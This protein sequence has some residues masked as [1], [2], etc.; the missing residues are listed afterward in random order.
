MVGHAQ[1]THGNRVDGHTVIA[2]TL[3]KLGV[4]HI[5]GMSGSP[6]RETLPACSKAG[7]RPI[8]VHNQQAAVMMA[9]A[10]NFVGGQLTGVAILSAGPAITNA[11]TGVL[12]AKDNGWPVVVLG[13]RRPLNMKGMGSFQELDAIPI[14][15]SITKWAAVI[16]TTADIPDYLSRAVQV[17]TTGRPGPVY[18]DVSEEALMGT[19]SEWDSL[20]SESSV[21]PR[22]DSHTISKA[23]DI[24]LQ[25]KRPALIIGTDIRWSE[26]YE[27]LQKLVD[28]LNLPFITSP[29]GRGFL[30]DDHPL[31]FNAARGLLQ[32]KADVVLLVG[33]RLD[34]TFRFGTELTS[35]AKLILVDSHDQ[36]IGMNRSPDVG[37]IGDVPYVLQE[38]LDQLDIERQGNAK[39]KIHDD[40][41]SLLK[42]RRVQN[43]QTLESRMT[44]DTIP[45][46]P[47]RLAKEIRDFLPSNAI[48][49]LDGNV[50]MAAAQ[51]V[52]PTY[53]PASRLT[54]G[55]NGCMGVGIPFGIG[56]KLTCP[57][58]LVVVICGDLAFGINAMEMETAI[59]HKIP[60]IVV[61]A[62]N[63][64]ISGSM[65][66]KTLYPTNHER[67]TMFQP[68]IRYEKIMEAFGGYA[69]Y[70]EHPEQLKGALE[71]AVKSGLP[72]CLNVKVDPDAPYL[73]VRG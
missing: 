54:A 51:D 68:G 15:Q 22:P 56:A 20:N 67:V 61:V 33:A 53:T 50:S 6:I 45:M 39:K 14:F 52:I 8:G 63:E 43:F 64:G 12:V 24:L 31:C 23:A 73:V 72:A 42:E 27:E 16:E 57:D 21:P 55:T 70:V 35:D 18:L 41:L 30:S 26:P 48:C 1:K 36:E 59:R 60:I 11:V 13:G 3:K 49:V 4:T 38:L 71:R 44:V 40:W 47:H 66:H 32:S 5:Y 62:N 34:W 25:A 7:I 10:Q 19:V 28:R 37:L 46:S 17:A 9:A 2:H 29:M 58:R 65:S 69:E